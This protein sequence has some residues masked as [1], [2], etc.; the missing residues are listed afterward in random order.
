MGGTAATGRIA[1]TNGT[2]AFDEKGE[3][4]R[5]SHVSCLSRQNGGSSTLFWFFHRPVVC[6]KKRGGSDWTQVSQGDQILDLLDEVEGG[7]PLDDVI[8]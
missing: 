7:K 4:W 3:R 1:A 2:R 8:I 5:L 6:I